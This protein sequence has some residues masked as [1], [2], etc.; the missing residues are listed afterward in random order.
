MPLKICPWFVLFSCLLRLELGMFKYVDAGW[1]RMAVENP[2]F[3]KWI[4]FFVT[5]FSDCCIPFY[6]LP[7]N[8]FASIFECPIWSLNF[9]TKILPLKYYRLVEPAQILPFGCMFIH[10]YFIFWSL[11]LLFLCISF[12]WFMLQCFFNNIKDE[13][14]KMAPQ[15]YSQLS[16]MYVCMYVFIKNS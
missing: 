9:T 3:H 2:A 6:F 13:S 11:H 15:P 10:I 5:D 1:H 4:E 16:K 8:F 14:C 7:R 12:H